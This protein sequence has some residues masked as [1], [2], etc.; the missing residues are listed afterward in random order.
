MR[1]AQLLA[2]VDP[3]TFATQPFAVGQPSTSQVRRHA[4]LAEQLD[5]LPVKVLGSF[6]VLDERARARLGSLCPLGAAGTQSLRQAIHGVACNVPPAASRSGLHQL[7][8][9]P[10]G[11][12]D[13]VRR[14]RLLGRVTCKLVLAEAVVKCRGRVVGKRD[15]ASLAS[16][17]GLARHD[18]DQARGSRRLPPPRRQQER[19]VRERVGSRS[20]GELPGL[21]HETGRHRQVSSQDVIFSEVIERVRKQAQGAGSARELCLPGREL[22]PCPVVPQVQRSEVVSHTQPIQL[23]LLVAVR[24]QRPLQQRRGGRVAIGQTGREAEQ[25]QLPGR[26]RFRSDWRRA[27][28]ARNVGHVGAGCEARRVD[29]CDQR[30]EIRVPREF[31]IEWLQRSRRPQ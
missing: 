23:P 24:A 29:H 11:S 21:G 8:Q 10:R 25:Q 30:L 12:H 9:R 5:R 31:G 22:E 19:D 13:F 1:S 14:A 6:T 17:V 7:V 15:R 26:Q 20:R 3:P 27:G 4:A 18:L 28:G 16:G 2:G